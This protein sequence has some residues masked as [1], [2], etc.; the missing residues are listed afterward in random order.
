MRRLFLCLDITGLF[1]KFKL[2]QWDTTA[3]LL[4]WLKFKTL[5]IS[6]PGKD[7]EQQKLFFITG[8]KGKWNTHFGSLSVSYTAEQGLM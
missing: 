5:K 1:E 6:I 2:R 4:E 7:A 8:Y 3:D